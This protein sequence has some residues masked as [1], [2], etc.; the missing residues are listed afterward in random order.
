MDE[1]TV[2]GQIL[3]D[4]NL[5]QYKITTPS[6]NIF[7]LVA[8]HFLDT[9]KDA[10]SADNMRF[11]Q[12]SRVAQIYQE[13]KEEGKENII[14]AGTLNEVC[15]SHFLSPLL[16]QTDLKDITKH[17][18]FNVDIDTGRD[19][20]YYRMGAYRMGVNIKQKDYMLLS[21]EMFKKVR[22]SGLNRKAI[23]PDKPGKWTI[24]NSILNKE[25]AAS[26]HPVIWGEIDL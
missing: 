19:A 1:K 5:L 7:W 20:D 3:F 8:V 13:M 2:E 9:G 18:V 25:Q 4:S 12:S 24:Y 11:L 26:E 22:K 15:Y 16:Q 10:E 6:N 14:I 21:P 23:W 17:Q